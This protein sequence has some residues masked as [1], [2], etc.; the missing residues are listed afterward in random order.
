M[1]TSVPTDTLLNREELVKL[2]CTADG[3]GEWPKTAQLSLLFKAIDDLN[4]NVAA[5]QKEWEENNR[6]RQEQTNLI[7]SLQNDLFAWRS[8]AKGYERR[9]DELGKL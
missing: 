3:K 4:S 6:L 5:I 7:V 2:L 1:N 8:V 9:L